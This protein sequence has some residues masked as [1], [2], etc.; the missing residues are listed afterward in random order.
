[1]EPLAL[2]AVKLTGYVPGFKKVWVGFCEVE[3]VPSPKSQLQEVGEL[4]VKS[5]KETEFPMQILVWFAEKS[6]T[7]TLLIFTKGLFGRLEIEPKVK[8][9][10]PK[11]PVWLDTRPSELV[12]LPPPLEEVNELPTTSHWALNTLY[13]ANTMLLWS[14]T[15]LL[16]FQFKPTSQFGPWRFHQ[17]NSETWSNPLVGYKVE[18]LLWGLVSYLAM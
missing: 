14:S 12:E 3:L 6:A 2:V 15:R 10:R 16:A 7:G 11:L 18:E 5:V 1:M 8:S 4:V 9:P 13:I 17:Y